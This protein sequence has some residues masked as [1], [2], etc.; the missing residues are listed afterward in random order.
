MGKLGKWGMNWVMRRALAFTPKRAY[1][2]GTTIIVLVVAVYILAVTVPG[3]ITALSTASTSGWNT[4]TIALWGI[5]PV[6]IVAAIILYVFQRR[7]SFGR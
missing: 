4:N 5:L 7:G 3:A 6:V 2:L 1:D